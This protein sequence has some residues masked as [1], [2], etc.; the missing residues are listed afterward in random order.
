MM[1]WLAL[2]AMQDYKRNVLFVDEEAGPVQTTRILAALGADPE[3]IDKCF[4]YLPYP[5]IRLNSRDIGALH[6]LMADKRPAL[7]L[8]DSSAA[9]MTVA[10]I[11]E[12]NADEV[13]RFWY[14]LLLPLAS[15]FGSSVVITDHDSRT[16]DDR[17]GRGSTAKLAATQVAFKIWPVRP[18]TRAQD[19]LLRLAVVKDRPGWL[20][21]HHQVRVSRNPLRMLFT[22]AT[23]PKPDEKPASAM[24]CMLLDVLSD[25]PQSLLAIA[26]KLR[27]KAG[28]GHPH[29]AIREGLDELVAGQQADRMDLGPGRAVLWVNPQPKLDE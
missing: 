6:E 2:R 9:M 23:E 17:Y 4:T 5:T 13:T 11:K 20:H 16:A 18:F 24:A 29:K 15:D 27:E 26:D 19:G 7:T 3:L 25:T 22:R 21:R 12:N 10:G 8:M 1:L 28:H 14:E